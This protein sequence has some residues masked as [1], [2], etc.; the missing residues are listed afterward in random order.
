[1]R[2]K[3]RERVGE[4]V[5]VSKFIGKNIKTTPVSIANIPTISCLYKS[6]M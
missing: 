6:G 2:E 4:S 5:C 1:M 3:E